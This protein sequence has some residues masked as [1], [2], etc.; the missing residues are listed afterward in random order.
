L[1]RRGKD[2]SKLRRVVD[3]ILKGEQLP[4][5]VRDHFLSPNWRGRREC[6]IEPDWLL[7]YLLRGDDEVVF[8]R[9]GR[10]TDLFD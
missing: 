5:Q 6:H 3:A 1:K 2:L 4:D 8:E 7:I 10:H 9:T